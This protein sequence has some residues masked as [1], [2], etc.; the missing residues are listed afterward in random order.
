MKTRLIDRKRCGIYVIVNTINNKKYVGKSKDIH[1]RI[2]QHITQLN[3]KSKDENRHLINSWHKYGR[4][5]FD[6]FIVE[7][8]WPDMVL[9]AERELYWMEQLNTVDRNHGYNLRMDSTS[10][11]IVHDE[12]R[13]L[14]SKAGKQKHIDNPNLRVETG[15]KLSKYWKDNVEAKE[16]MGN[17]VS[18][19]TTNYSIVKLDKD[20]NIIDEF[21]TQKI[22]KETLPDYYLPAILQVCNGNKSSYKGFYWRYRDIKTSLIKEVNIKQGMR[23]LKAVNTI[24]GEECIYES[25]LE[26]EKYSDIKRDA[27]YKNTIAGTKSKKSIYQYY[28]I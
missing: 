28:W 11:M 4:E 17:L 13:K 22:L 24:T 19:A 8:L 5:N 16:R 18:N 3:T 6:Y 27:I 21:K 25:V 26:A 7:Y 14:L 20:F 10:N 1:K 9:L 15:K 2:K 12:T 23:K